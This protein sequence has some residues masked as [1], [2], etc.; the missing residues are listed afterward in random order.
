MF[1]HYIGLDWAQSNMAIARMTK[2]NIQ[3]KVINVASSLKE[4]QLYLS[5]FTRPKNTDL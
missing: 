4:L 2:E 3:A 1:D 5:R